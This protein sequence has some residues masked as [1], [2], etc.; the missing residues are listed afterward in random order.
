MEAMETTTFGKHE[1]IH[2]RKDFLTLYEHGFRRHSKHFTVI[3]RRNE[4]GLRRLGITV[5]KKVGIAVQRNRI[6]RLLR[7]FFRLHKTGIS[8]SLDI[9]IIAKKDAHSL[10]YQGV[11]RELEILLVRK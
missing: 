3:E 5:T 2:K 7:E 9:V 4:E 1:R 8:S 10:T 6:K 11:C